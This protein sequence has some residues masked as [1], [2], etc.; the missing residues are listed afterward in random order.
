MNHLSHS[1]LFLA[2]A[3]ALSHGA[4]AADAPS[5]ADAT[6]L[7]Q[8]EVEASV[9]DE[10][11]AESS[12]PWGKASLKSTPAQVNVIG[13]DQIEDRHIRTLS[14]LAREDASAG[15]G[16]APVGYYQNLVIRGFPL[17]LGTGYRLN[18]LTI[19]GEQILALEDKAR[20]EILKGPAALEA[21][22]MEPGGAVNFVSKRPEEV[23]RITLGTDSHGSRLA[24]L[25]AGTWLTPELGVRANLGW[26]EMHSFVRHADGRRNFYALALDWRPSE[27]TTLE[28]DANYHASAQ[29]S[30]SG[31]QLLGASVI[32]EDASAT[33]MLGYQPWQ[34][35]VGIHSTNTSA[36]LSHRFSD[37]WQAQISVGHSRSVIDDYVAF[38]YGCYYQPACWTGEVPGNFFAPDGGYDIYDYRNPDDTRSSDELRVRLD[39]RFETGAVQHDL[40]LGAGAFR[41]E[42]ERH[43]SVNEFIGSGNIHDPQVPVHSPSPEAIGPRVRRLSSWQHSLF[44]MDRMRLGAHW[45]LLLGARLV[46][47]DDRA[48][49]KRG[50][51][52]RDAHLSHTLPQVA[53][54]WAPSETL[55]LYASYSEGL[56]LGL[57]APFWTSNDGD[58][59]GPRLSRQFELGAKFGHGGAVDYSAALFRIRQPWQHAEPDSTDAGYTF[60]ERGSEN[61]LGLELSAN[62]QLG[63]NLRLV[64]SGSLIRARGENAGN[65]AYEG[66]QLANVPRVRASVHFDYRLPALPALSLLAGA[67]H[68]ARNPATLDGQVHVPSWTVWDAGLRYDMRWGERELTWRLSVDN[69]TDRFYWRDTGSA[70]GDS[71]LFPGAPRLARL[72]VAIDL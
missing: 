27:R 34:S 43:R 17:D 9:P 71:Y 40:S 29:R 57:E 58:L 19:T 38:A 59:L 1:L 15:D 22:A 46:Q 10:A 33:L 61:H 56:S 65:A 7:S 3:S 53:A 50:A 49:S 68:A 12:G 51:L 69:L 45:Q 6:R 66:H 60:I 28:L 47:L 4:R 44:A 42:I 16:Y 37:R 5:H 70:L 26:E 32:P 36:R 41:R 35:P 62:A 55:M 48:W 24:A 30:V 18:G 72:S 21:G 11:D 20:V 23:R 52:E 39:G 64:A 8:V 63:E 14:E 25:D 31:Y 54:L 67:R 13:R 2:L